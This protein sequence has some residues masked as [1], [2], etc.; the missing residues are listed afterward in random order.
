M[1]V[2]NGWGCLAICVITFCTAVVINTIVDG[3]VECKRPRSFV[4]MLG[5]KRKEGGVDAKKRT[6]TDREG[7]R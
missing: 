3:I 1:F 7:D 4:D 2:V 6:G 5:G